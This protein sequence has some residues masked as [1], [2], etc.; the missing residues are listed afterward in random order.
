[1][2]DPEPAANGNDIIIKGGSIEVHFDDGGYESVPG[3]PKNKKNSK[4]KMTQIV[5]FDGDETGP[6]K[7]NSGLHP[8]GLK[9]LVKIS[10]PGK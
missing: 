2:S 7:F 5:I 10:T 8:E 4:K 3:K 1:M 9:W 6:E